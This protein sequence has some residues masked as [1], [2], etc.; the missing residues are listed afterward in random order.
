MR[1]GVVMPQMGEAIAEGN[2]TRWM[3]QIGDT[4]SRHELLFETS[5][6]KVDDEI[7]APSAGLL[8]EINH[9]AGE[10]VP[11]NAVRD[12][13]EPA[14]GAAAKAD[15]AAAAASP[16][17]KGE[18][19]GPAPAPA[20]APAPTAARPPAA[21]PAPEPAGDGGA[22]VSPVVRKIAAEHGI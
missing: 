3:K 9:A 6:D 13:L 20:P 18:P 7:P 22:F 4:V 21:A 11:V 16:S 5:T 10:T 8:V 12:I 14:A 1:V 15:P 19:A 17:K 2:I